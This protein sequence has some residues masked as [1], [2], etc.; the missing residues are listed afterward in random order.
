[1]TTLLYTHPSFFEHDTGGGHPER[2][3]RLKSIADALA[4]PRFAALQRREAGEATE[5]RLRLI[6]SEAHVRKVLATIPASGHAYLDPDTVVS[7]GSRAAALHAVGAVCGAI[8]AVIAGQARNA[9][10][11]VRPPGHHAEPEKA[12]GFCLFNNVAIGAAY[13]LTQRGIKRVAV[14]DFD[15]HHGN[16]TQAAFAHRPE[17]FYAS[18]HQSPWYPG[19]GDASETGV[20]NVLNLP[21][22]AGAGRVLLQGVVERG[23]LPALRRFNPDLMLISA[24]FDAHRDDP[25]ASLDWVED[26]FAW[27]TRQLL[28]V[29]R[30]CCGGKVVSALEGGYD[31]NAL[32]R[33]VAAHVNELLTDG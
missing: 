9:F 29:A 13:A 1:M 16:G 32:G 15:V 12:M 14:V 24:G 17:V 28:R 5:E 18:T 27:L 20:G 4:A 7:S 26:D 3:A 11:A 22:P 19:T 6:H 25:L 31:L 23:L 8:D 30:E 21:L 10:C 2:S 33:S